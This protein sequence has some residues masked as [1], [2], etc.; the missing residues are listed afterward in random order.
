MRKGQIAICLVMVLVVICVLALL[1]VDTFVAVRTKNR[2]QNGGDAAAL[3][4]AHKQGSLINEIGQ[5][6]MKHVVAALRNDARSCWEIEQLQRRLCLLGPIEALR[7]ANAAAKRNGMPVDDSFSKILD[8]HVR[9]VRLVYIGG[10]GDG[11]PYPESFTDAWSDYASAILDVVREGLATGPDNIEFY[12]S[13]AGHMLLVRQFYMAIAGRDW[14]WF[15]FNAE[16]LLKNYSSYRNWSPLPES[17]Q[18][19]MENSEI[20]SL[21]LS[22]RRTALTDVF[23]I[24]EIKQ[25]VERYTDEDFDRLVTDEDGNVDYGMIGDCEQTWFFFDRSAWR[26]WFDGRRLADDRSGYVFPIVGE[27]LEEY[28]VLG[29]AAVCRCRQDVTASATDAWATMN[30]SAAAKPFGAVDDFEGVRGDVTSLRRFV[31][32][33][34]TDVRLVAVDSVGCEDLATADIGWVHHLRN[35]LGAYMLHGPLALGEDC[36]YCRQLKTWEREYFRREGIEW[37]KYNAGLC[38]RGTGGGDYGRGGTAHGH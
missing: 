8:E 14:C 34:M 9:V 21:H 17:N 23:S 18:N 38:I 7:Q 20:F 4:A 22:A 19:S 35:H 31:V 29:C 26:Q 15:H 6:N 27:I 12:H 3:A 28:N 32:P 30:W 33:C 25:L 1:N 10:G 13:L 2:V 11:D 36:F 24:E 5:L 37:L 16:E